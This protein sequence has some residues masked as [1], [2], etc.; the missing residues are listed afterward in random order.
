MVKKFDWNTIEKSTEI[1]HKENTTIRI[2][3]LDN[4]V[5]VGEWSNP[6]IENSKVKPRYIFNVL[7]MNLNKEK[8]LGIISNPLM[9]ELK[10]YEPLENKEFSI[11]KYRFG[12][13]DF[14]IEYEVIH[15]NPNQL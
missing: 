2:K 12:A 6:N 5:D 11:R 7:E 15:L 8:T 4:D 10:K 9:N 1:I 3:F 14:D 13:T